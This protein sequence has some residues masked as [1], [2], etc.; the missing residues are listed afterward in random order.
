MLCY[1]L[2]LLLHLD[3]KLPL[4]L[5]LLVIYS[6]SYVWW[7][8]AFVRRVVCGAL[9]PCSIQPATGTTGTSAGTGSLLDSSDL[10][11]ARAL[12]PMAAAAAPFLLRRVP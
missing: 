8:M 12:R 1:L 3:D 10:H 7:Q 9:L 11:C 4:L 2:L 6:A 5:A